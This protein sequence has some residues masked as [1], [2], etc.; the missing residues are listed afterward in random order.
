MSFHICFSFNLQ[1][2]RGAATAAARVEGGVNE[3]Q[4]WCSACAYESKRCQIRHV[5][6]GGDRLTR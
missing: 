3:G 1:W 2:G 4:K 5:K 6:S